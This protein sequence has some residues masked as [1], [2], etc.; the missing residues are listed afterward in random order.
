VGSRGLDGDS[1]GGEKTSINKPSA[2]GF[3]LPST[4]SESMAVCETIK[5]PLVLATILLEAFGKASPP[6][7]QQA[8][9]LGQEPL[10]DE[11][12]VSQ[13]ASA[14]AHAVCLEP[15]DMCLIFSSSV[16]TTHRLCKLLQIL[17]GQQ[18]DDE[19]EEEDDEGEE[20]GRSGIN[21]KKRGSG[22]KGGGGAKDVGA[23]L[24]GGK[25]AEMSR[26]VHSD[27]R[28]RV[29]RQ[30]AAGLI[31]VLVSSDHMARGI[32]L[33]NIKLVINYDPPK[34]ASTYVHRVGRTA[35][36][37][38]TGHAVTLLKTGQV[39]AF[40]KMR[41]QITGASDKKQLQQQQQHQQQSKMPKC[42]PSKANEEFISSRVKEA[43]RKLPSAL[44]LEQS[45]DKGVDIIGADE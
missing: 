40:R 11:Q 4:L 45:Y 26:M 42:K 33:S 39:G 18:H 27:G 19:E 28:D 23:L 34:M 21:K 1:E 13:I 29:M 6:L 15:G 7:S 20:G 5:R 9:K 38:R 10:E 3:M 31:R 30:A 16:D 32:D 2:S 22:G 35:R 41:D 25:V 37:S 44:G 14:P 24:F 17:N 43:L 8:A 36:A 12:G